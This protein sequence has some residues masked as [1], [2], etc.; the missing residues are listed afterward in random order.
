MKQAKKMFLLMFTLVLV[1][2]VIVG[3]GSNNTNN[4]NS[5]GNK[6]KSGD[7]QVT[8]TVWDFYGSTT[9]IEPLIPAF[10]EE[11]PN[12]KVDFQSQ[13]WDNYWEKLAA[14]ATG[15]TLPDVA[16]TGPMF[17][18]Q[19]TTYGIYTDVNPLSNG[20][21]N[22]EKLQDVFSEGMLEA[23]TI[24]DKLYA[25]PYDFDAYALFYRADLLEEEGLKPPT[26][27]DEFIEVGQKITKDT[28]GDGKFDQYAFAVTADW[29]RWEPFL[30]GN[31]GSILNEDNTEAVF[32]S[33]EAVESL[34]F[35]A[36][37][38]NKYEIAEYWSADAGNYVQGLQDG[39]IAMI[40]DGP[41]VMGLL[42]EGAPELEGKWGV[43]SP[44]GNKEFG[45][46]IGGTYLS[47]FESSENK[48]EA[49]KF[50]EFLS[51]EENQ[52]A[53]YHT[54]GAA[55]AYLPAVEHDEV[56]VEDPYFSNQKPLTVFKDAVDSGK[57]NPIVA[58]WGEIAEILN[59]AIER[60]IIQD[61]TPQEALDEAAEQVN[62]IL[63]NN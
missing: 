45:T 51:R 60:A 52:V 35:Y 7:E 34:Q 43:A 38:V 1:S 63:A 24:D 5:D 62:E 49:W 57:P 56:A 46:H 44:V 27:W 4:S 30:Y 36:D 53:L 29:P 13:P 15:G 26:N 12:I 40:M 48:E 47:I 33:P 28:D 58:E 19:Y 31:G 54:S 18:P 20:E 10:E 41:Y 21:V 42:K 6:D 25:I 50:V 11:F 32:N 16:T 8:I 61:A 2:I 3:C 37:L 55:P 14:G 22:G 17:A 59:L 9:P 39:S 23:A